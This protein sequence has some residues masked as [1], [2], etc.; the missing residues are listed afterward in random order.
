MGLQI[1]IQEHGPLFTA[2]FGDIDP[3]LLPLLDGSLKAPVGHVTLGILLTMAPPHSACSLFTTLGFTLKIF[4]HKSKCG[5]MRRK[6][7]HTT[8]NAEMLM[9]KLGARS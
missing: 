5:E 3:L 8:I 7:S 9:M 1:R 2:R 6:A 4:S